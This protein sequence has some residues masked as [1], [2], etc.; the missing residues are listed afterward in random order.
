MNPKNTSPFFSILLPTKN[1]SHLV[2]Y[3]IRSVLQQDFTN[4]ELI[5]C[6]N[7]DD[8]DATRRVVKQYSDQRIKYI[9]TGGL[10]MIANW[11]TA[12]N[13]AT[14][15]HVIVLEDKMIFY[16][17]ALAAIKQIIE[18]SPSG[19]VVWKTDIIED[20]G[21]IPVLIH[22]HVAEDELL[23]SEVVLK[24]VVTNVMFNWA[25]LPRGLCCS[26][27]KA[28]I[29]AIMLKTGN[30]FYEE[31]SPDF[32]SAIKLLWYIDNYIMSGN[33]FNLITSNKVSNGK[34]VLF[35][36]FKDF[37]YFMGNKK[38]QLNL[39]NV[40]VKSQWIQVNL[41][42]ADYLNQRSHLGGKLERFRVS[43][44]N[45]FEMLF[46]ELLVTSIHEKKILWNK[47]EIWQ[48]FSGGDGWI[49]NGKYG[50]SF[51][52]GLLMNKLLKYKRRTRGN[53]LKLPISTES[54]KFVEEY[55]NGTAMIKGRKAF[56]SC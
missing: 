41:V 15:Q 3:A 54:L 52:T 8:P 26:V 56:A 35:R 33:T 50:I 12:L 34:N 13:A 37:D 51:I 19:I 9:R 39:E 4:F 20:E 48:L 22:Q 23:T 46:Q 31:I 5:I 21:E 36:K 45:Y 38:F 17:G 25:I 16:A 27:P 44:R 32:V 42:I 10:D 40:Y 47:E 14:G 55:L 2:G 29:D 30:P 53:V 6:D 24:K 7:D 18:V 11:N 43:N 1:R 49:A 28:T